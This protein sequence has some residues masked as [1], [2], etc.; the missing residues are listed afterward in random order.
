MGKQNCPS[1]KGLLDKIVIVKIY[2]FKEVFNNNERDN[3][4]H[5]ENLQASHLFANE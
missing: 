2:L 1:K 5:R 3:Y 4:T